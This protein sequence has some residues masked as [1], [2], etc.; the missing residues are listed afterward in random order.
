LF[1][2]PWGIA[3]DSFTNIYVSDYDSN[4]IRK[5]SRIDATAN[6]A[7]TTI[8]GFPGLSGSSDGTNSLAFFNHP[9]GLLCDAAGNVYVADSGNRVVRKLSRDVTGTN[10]FSTT[11]A[12]RAGFYGHA[13]GVA[14]NATFSS[15]YAL[16]LDPSGNIYITDGGNGL[17]RILGT[18]G[19]VTTL[20][21]SSGSADG[22]YTNAGFNFPYGIA[23]DPF[24]NIYVSDTFNY[25]IRV[26]HIA[27]VIVPSVSIASAGQNSVVSWPVPTSPYRLLAA[28]NLAPANWIA[29]TNLPRTFANQNV[30]TNSSG[31]GTMFYRLVN[32]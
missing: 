16:A 19:T 8:A 12:G 14:T 27:Q 21:G 3:V 2:S 32:P 20:A 18:N 11:V 22:Y 6:W 15:P 28:T 24:G 23:I 1:S 13:D 5:V 26:A 29:V 4:V 10:W 17:I 30:V 9:A 7:V 31:S 25:T